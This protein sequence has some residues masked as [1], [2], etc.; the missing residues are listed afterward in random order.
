MRTFEDDDAGLYDALAIAL[1]RPADEVVTALRADGTLRGA[2]LLRAD[3]TH[4]LLMGPLLVAPMLGPAAFLIVYFLVKLGI[5]PLAPPDKAIMPATVAIVVGSVLALTLGF[6]VERRVAWIPLVAG[7]AAVVFGGLTL[8]FDD[9]RFLYM[10]PTIMNLLFAS[11]MFGGVWLRK[12]PLKT[13]FQDTIRMTDVG[14]RRLTIRYG[15]FFV[16]VAALNEIVWRTQPEQVWVLFRMPGLLILPVVFSI[17]QV[18]HILKE[19][20]ALEAAAELEG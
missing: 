6:L 16:C 5:V 7:G 18:P 3:R 15:V 14:W 9:P 1:G 13:L 10:K 19:M 17:S 4:R 2:Q 20:K 12:N 8:V 11:V